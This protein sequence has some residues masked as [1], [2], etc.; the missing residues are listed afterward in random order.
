[1]GLTDKL[2]TGR[3]KTPP[4]ILA[5]GGQGIGKSTWAA[6]AAKA[7]LKPV[8]QPTESVAQIDAVKLPVAKSFEEVME[9]LDA[10]LTEPHEFRMYVLDT[11][12]F[13]EA[14]VWEYVCRTRAD[15]KTGRKYKTVQDWPYG[16][17]YA[18]AD[19]VWR[20][21]QQKVLKL[22]DERRM[23]ILMLAHAAS[24]TVAEPGMEAYEV[25]AP[26]LHVSGKGVGVGNTLQEMADC[27][28]YLGK[29]KWVEKKG[30][31]FDK[32]NVMTGV[33]KRVIHAE[34][35]A[36]WMAKNRYSLPATIDMGD[37]KTSDF[38]IFWNELKNSEAF[39]AGKNPA[40]G[41]A[42]AAGKRGGGNEEEAI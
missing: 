14:L 31:G 29:E 8:F 17:G 18:V 20:Q 27:V 41:Q 32:R 13:L 10:L 24:K 3:E 6:S 9:N 35:G 40:R 39:K 37:E 5:Y 42:D 12:D 11:L 33:G 34:E 23:M 15:E 30:E 25:W 4:I 28:L 21:W 38:R 16:Q 7:G 19:G 36:G 26:K 22:R 2:T 1:M